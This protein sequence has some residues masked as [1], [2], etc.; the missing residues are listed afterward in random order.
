MIRI[1]G[2]PGKDLCD[3]HLG[4][5]RRDILRVGGSAML[6][7][8][9]G[10]ML[11][12]KANANGGGG[13]GR[14]WGK[15]KSVIMVYLQGGP[16]H[17][18][19]W[20]PKENV[21][22]NVRS[23]FKTI[24]TKIPGVHFTELLPN[25]ARVNDK[26]SMIRSLS[27]TPN[28]L[29]NHTAA[30]YQIMTGY[31]TDKVSPSGQLEP[32][33]P[34]DFPNFGSN[35][36]RLRPPTEP[37]LPFVMLP[38]PLQESN[39]VGK[40]GSAGFLGKSYDPYTLYPDGDDMDMGKMDNIKVDDL[41][42]RPDVFS[43]RLE[44]RG[45]LRADIDAAMPELEKAVEQ[46]SV[47]EYY[48]QAMNLIVS[49]RARNAFDLAQEP[50]RL[51]DRYGRNTFGQS[52]LLAR[53]LVESGTRVVEVI[54]PKVANSNNH[55]WD[56]HTGLNDRMKKQSAPML[57]RGLSSLIS[58]LDERGL[59][60]DTLVVALGEFGRSPEKGVSTSGNNNSADGRDHWP[61][62]YTGVVAGAGTKRGYVHGKSDKTGS[63][64]L[65]KPVHPTE[66]LASI[67][68]AFG[69]DPETVV[70][71]HLN[72]PRELVKAQAVTDLFA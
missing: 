3:A 53:R 54:W 55:S 26:F 43:H 28:G 50:E 19:L 5:T 21:P 71:N 14:G 62:C 48:Q 39:V 72:Q 51:R 64:P 31:T 10:G 9:L 44:R 67:Y 38:R 13:G 68:H 37:M 65:E 35:I 18:D 34:K 22:D 58:D 23:N 33:S 8:S 16:S 46:Y 17:L 56:V 6:G 66:L 49:G 12:L 24:P 20:D 60:D 45:R 63:A 70:Y 15:A 1:P 36:I 25:L 7:L 41:K 27:Y 32:P 11:N 29:F 59:L 57:D 2:E 47:N 30:I 61:Y 69:I 52:C 4:V 40:G 42:L